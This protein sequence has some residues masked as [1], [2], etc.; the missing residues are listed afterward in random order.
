MFGV[1]DGNQVIAKFSTPLS[2]KSVKPIYASD[3]LSLKRMIGRKGSAQRW[4]IEAQLEPTVW[5]AGRLFAFFASNG[6]SN[7]IQIVMPQPY[8]AIDLLKGYTSFSVSG[9]VGSD[10]LSTSSI[11][12]PES[13]IGCFVKFQSHSKIYIIKEATGNSLKVF[14]N[15][16]F[17]ISSDTLY[18][19]TF[20]LGDFYIDLDVINGM[21]YTDGIVM[22]LG[23]VKFVEAL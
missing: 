14:P 20:I 5:G 17:P 1:Y 15:V 2:V 10:S 16:I 21:T 22:D 23:T 6:S 12:D 19:N 18:L 7:K 11:P 8:N 3:T 13:V 4:E 9:S